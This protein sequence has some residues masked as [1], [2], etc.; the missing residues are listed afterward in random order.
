MTE[1]NDDLKV[2]HCKKCGCELASTNKGNL[3]DNCRS[4]KDKWIKRGLMGGLAVLFTSVASIFAVNNKD[5][6]N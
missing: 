4:K 2:R 3:C 6:M 1:K 5:K